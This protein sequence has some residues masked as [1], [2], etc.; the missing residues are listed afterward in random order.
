MEAVWTRFIPAMKR[1]VDAVEVGAIGD[2]VSIDVDFGFDGRDGP[3]RLMDPALAGGALYDLGTYG[4]H[5]GTLL[6]G[7]SSDQTMTKVLH[8]STKK[9]ADGVDEVFN[10]ILAYPSE[11]CLSQRQEGMS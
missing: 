5:L 4:F 7:I 3:A 8:T 6:S 9:R 1:I 2:V 10:V 11:V